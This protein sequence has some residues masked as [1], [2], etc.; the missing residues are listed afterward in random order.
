MSACTDGT[1]NEHSPPLLAGKGPVVV[2][3][4]GLAGPQHGA[5]GAELETD[6]PSVRVNELAGH[7]D[8]RYGGVGWYITE[9]SVG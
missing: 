9:V 6:A 4:G 5:E 7:N 8:M 3:A 2:S 1:W